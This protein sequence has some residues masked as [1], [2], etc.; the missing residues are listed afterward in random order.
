MLGQPHME[1]ENLLPPLSESTIQHAP[2]LKEASLITY[3]LIEFA[4]NDPTIILLV[5]RCRDLVRRIVSA[6]SEIEKLMHV[7]MPDLTPASSLDNEDWAAVKDW[8]ESFNQRMMQW[9]ELWPPVAS[10]EKLIPDI[11]QVCPSPRILTEQQKQAFEWKGLYANLLVISKIY[12]DLALNFLEEVD[13]LDF[14]TCL[15]EDSVDQ[16][17]VAVEPFDH[18]RPR[19]DHFSCLRKQVQTV[20]EQLRPLQHNR[21]DINDLLKQQEQNPLSKSQRRE[22]RN[23]VLAISHGKEQLIPNQI[24]LNKLN[25]R[26]IRNHMDIN[27]I[28]LPSQIQGEP[29][30]LLALQILQKVTIIAAYEIFDI[31]EK[32]IL[33]ARAGA[34]IVEMM[35]VTSYS[36]GPR[37]EISIPPWLSEEHLLSLQE[38]AKGVCEVSSHIEFMRACRKILERF[39]R[40]LSEI[41]SQTEERLRDK[42]SAQKPSEFSSKEIMETRTWL[43][44]FGHSEIREVLQRQDP[45]L[46]ID[47]NLG[48]LSF[49]IRGLTKNERIFIA[50][51]LAKGTPVR[52]S[53]AQSQVIEEMIK[54]K[55][56][57]LS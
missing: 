17:K 55:K 34:G 26:V 50:I 30:R 44:K 35:K 5:K 6:D 42:I 33:T 56:A 27:E 15:R 24:P 31:L 23:W 8:K 32:S 38:Q 53:F 28:I 2:H 47:F 16:L 39:Q 51:K 21:R 11:F 22:I 36:S 10:L 7:N 18:L 12:F 13:P 29:K 40:L 43:Q 46:S 45:R 49:S 20:S 54:R 48:K 37:L 9:G 52:L 3:K 57:E 25:S 14:I 4:D 41:P 19:F 1:G